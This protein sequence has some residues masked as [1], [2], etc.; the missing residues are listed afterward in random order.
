M[1]EPPR[2]PQQIWRM[3][4]CR[5]WKAVC[6]DFAGIKGASYS[7]AHEAFSARKRAAGATERCSLA[8]AAH[9]KPG[10]RGVVEAGEA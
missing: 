6:L 4:N 8:A 1:S 10:Q 5:C 7:C 2:L 3:R 9:L